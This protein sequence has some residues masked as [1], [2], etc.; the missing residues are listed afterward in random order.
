MNNT[1]DQ[2]ASIDG[3]NNTNK[4]LMSQILE[5]K[6]NYILRLEDEIDTMRKEIDGQR[7]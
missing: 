6:E 7:D 4:E 2:Q 3:A 5:E 1:L